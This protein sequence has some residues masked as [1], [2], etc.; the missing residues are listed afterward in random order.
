MGD[1]GA[2]GE[3]V[4]EHRERDKAMPPNCECTMR[5]IGRRKTLETPDPYISYTNCIKPLSQQ[6]VVVSA[7]PGFD[8]SATLPPQYKNTGL[9]L[10]AVL[11]HL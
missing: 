4:R 6:L 10:F 7:E 11:V 5:P 2:Q 8:E 3:V 1:R 9:P